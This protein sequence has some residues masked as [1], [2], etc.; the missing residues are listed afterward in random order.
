MGS[1]GR[2]LSR[3]TFSLSGSVSL[4]E[5]VM[6]CVSISAFTVLT[7]RNNYKAPSE[8]VKFEEAGKTRSTMTAF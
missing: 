5:L 3:R 4:P 2:P 8:F 6:P 1:Y 7:Y